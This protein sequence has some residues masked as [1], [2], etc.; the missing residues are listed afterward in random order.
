[1]DTRLR[2]LATAKQKVTVIFINVQTIVIELLTL[3]DEII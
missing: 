1:M 2:Q 3:G